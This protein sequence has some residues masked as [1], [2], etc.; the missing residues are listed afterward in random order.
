MQMSCSIMDTANHTSDSS[1]PL[2]ADISFKPTRLPISIYCLIAEMVFM[3]LLLGQGLYLW[4]AIFLIF[5]SFSG[6]LR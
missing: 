6:F 5:A 2:R 3:A 1:A 4:L